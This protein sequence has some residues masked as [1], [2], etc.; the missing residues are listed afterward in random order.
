[1]NAPLSAQQLEFWLAGFLVPLLRITPFVSALPVFGRNI[2]LPVKIFLSVWLAA[3][4]SVTLPDHLKVQRLDDISVAM[5]AQQILIG[6]A[7]G[8]TLRFV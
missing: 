1:M 4:V 2:P 5:A 7:L 8:M 6:L 3:I